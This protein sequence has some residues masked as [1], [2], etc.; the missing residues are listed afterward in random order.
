VRLNRLPTLLFLLLALLLAGCGEDVPHL[1]PL[2]QH[3]V[4]L[5]FGDSLTYGT[6]AA[7]D[8]SYPAV[9]ERLSGHTVINAGKP[10]E[11]TPAGLA[12]L[13]RELDAYQPELLVL[14]HG[15]NDMLRRQSKEVMQGNLEQMVRLAHERGIQV[16]MLSV[17]RPAILSRTS[18]DT[19]QSVAA[20]LEVPLEDKIISKVLSD[21]KL[22][23]DQIHPNAEGYRLIAESV[24]LLLQKAGAL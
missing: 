8:S 20:K 22:M 1:N 21:S 4:I 2:S 18:A 19:Y 9:L 7:A 6:G 13:A 11:Q 24:Y 5:A 10:G 14:C 15:G 17:P 16:V 12:R 3:A 23:S